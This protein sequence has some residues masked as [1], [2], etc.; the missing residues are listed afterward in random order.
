MVRN[1]MRRW[2]PNDT[3]HTPNSS[4]DQWI[5]S[6]IAS[7]AVSS[8]P[9]GDAAILWRRHRV[10]PINFLHVPF[11]PADRIGD[12]SY[13]SRDACPAIVLRE[14]TRCEDAG[15]DQQHA[16]ATLVHND[17]VIIFAFCSP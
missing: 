12:G 4:H 5:E 14:P 1:G 11:C 2:T 7:S 10:P 9:S 3:I 13:S 17:Q 15:G 16:L 8:E 6:R